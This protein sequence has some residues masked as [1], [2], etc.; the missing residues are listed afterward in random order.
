MNEEKA[1]CFRC[2]EF[3]VL[4]DYRYFELLQTCS[5]CLTDI[6]IGYVAGFFDGEGHVEINRSNGPNSLRLAQAEPEP[7]QYILERFPG[8]L[9]YRWAN[10]HRGIFNLIYNGRKALPLAHVMLPHLIVRRHE[11]ELYLLRYSSSESL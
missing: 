2:F 11:V 10:Q 3:K 7:L 6:D 8:G 9:V 1:R 4:S 5:E